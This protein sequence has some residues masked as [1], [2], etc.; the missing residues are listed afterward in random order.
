LVTVTNKAL[1]KPASGTTQ[2]Q[3]TILGL[4]TMA[5][6]EMHMNVVL[7]PERGGWGMRGRTARTA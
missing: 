2:P 3:I 1:T 4:D 5:E 7:P 6:H